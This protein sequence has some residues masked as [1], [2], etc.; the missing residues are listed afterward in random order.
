M[1]RLNPSQYDNEEDFISTDHL[2]R[3]SK[4]LKPDHKPKLPRTRLQGELAA[5]ADH[6]ESFNFTYQASRHERAWLIRSLGG[7]YEHHWIDNVLRLLKGGK[8]ASVY[9]CAANATTSAGEFIAAKVYRPR[10]FR[11]LKNDHLYREGR[12]NIDADGNQ[13]LD[14]GML[15]AMH[16]RTAYGMELMHGSWIMH[17]FQTLQ[18]LHAAGVDVPKPYACEDNAILMEYV[19]DPWMPAPTLNAVELDRDEATALF[20]RVLRNIDRMLDQERIHGDLS[21]YNILYWEGEIWLI[22]FPQAIH[23][24]E[25]RNAYRILMRDLM[26]ICDYFS[27]QG[28]K[29]DAGRIAA[30]LWTSHGRNIKPEIH[31]S[32]MGDEEP[33]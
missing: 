3:R 33:K 21:A 15:H 30:D 4:K 6:Q 19:G 17:E 11:S 32:L 5:Q 26:R 24:D 20:E 23:P 14:G 7:F 13:I 10:M 25:N 18:R 31:P 22:D 2:S 8:E 1:P 27:R 29:A 9:L 28:V 16:K 12:A